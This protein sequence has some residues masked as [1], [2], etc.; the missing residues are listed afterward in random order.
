V[1]DEVKP[2]VWL[3]FGPDGLSGHL[4][5][6]AVGRWASEAFDRI[7][8][9]AALYTVAVP[10]SLARRL[11]MHQ[12]HPVPDEAITLALDVSTV[13]EAKMSALR[14]HATQWTSSPMVNASEEERRLFFGK[15][16]FMRAACRDATADFLPGLLRE[17]VV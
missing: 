2:Q 5:H 4:D 1:V 14:C 8:E 13:W 12:V 3:S 11:G 7:G 16:Y 17:H 9:A 10:R 15:E 6:L